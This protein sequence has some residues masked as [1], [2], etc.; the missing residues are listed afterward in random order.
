MPF[1][2]YDSIQVKTGGYSAKFG[3]STGG[4]MNATS[5]SGTNEFK[6]GSNFYFDKEIET[7]PN[8]Y[9][10][11]N[12]KDAFEETNAD[13]YASGPI[14]KDRLFFYALY[15][16]NSEDEEY[17]GML[18]GRGYKATRDTDFWGVKLDGYISE[19][20]RV[21]L[22]AF[23][24]ERETIEGAYEYDSATENVGNYLGDTIYERGGMNWI[25]TYTGNL[26][27]TMT[28]SMS[29]GENEANRTTAPATA[30][31]PVVY[32]YDGGFIA[33]GDWTNF[34]VE[35]GEDKREM[36][37]VD[38]AWDLNDHFIEVGVDQESNTS[39]SATINSGG[40]YWL[41]DPNNTYNECTAAECPSGA[42]VRLRT[43]NVGGEFDVESTAFYIQDTWQATDQL[44]IQAGLRNESF[45]NNNGAGD[46][47]IEIDNQWAPRLSAV[48]DPTG[49][50]NQKV[51]ANWGMYYLPIA[52]NT[53]IRMAGNETYIQDYFDWDGSCLNADFTPCNVGGQFDQDLF[54]N[55]TVPD[56]RSL[57]DTN[58]EPMYQSEFILGYEYIT[59]QGMELGVK[60]IY[61][62]LETSIE[63]V[64]IDAAVI[65]YYNTNGGWT[66]G[67]TVEET[68]TGFHQYVLTNPG[69]DMEI[70]IP[71]TDE[72]VSLD[73]GALGYPEAERQYGALEFTFRRPFDGK[74]MVDASYTW[75]HSWGNNEGY[76]RSDNGQD[77]AGLTT[78]FD[79]PGLLD[80][81][82][83]NLPNDRRHTV[84]AFGTYQFDMGLRM[85][86]NFMWQSGR[87]QNCFGVHPTDGF[88]AAYGAES[89]YCQG[90]LASRG[91]FGRT[92]NRWNL[93]L[94]A[95]YPVEFANNQ[96][97]MVSL[98]VF[99]LLNNDAVTEVVETGDTDG[100]AVNPFFNEPVQYQSPRAVRLGVRY[101]FN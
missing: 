68:F 100:G 32:E 92:D 37:R 89:F 49:A 43:Y 19:N 31:I 7:S 58:I 85:G 62:N 55:G 84:K 83:G 78:N 66:A 34:T 36:M 75:G 40:A 12:D 70:Y 28:L 21:E 97:V 25:A 94:N 24:D 29:Y 73:A 1:E 56:T 64:A 98:D 18:S 4:V 39:V 26:T 10:A 46:P 72:F 93:D 63:D 45:K 47:F 101:E 30:D 27:D 22:T 60:G 82:K 67:G 76:V 6:F 53:N 81:G 17:Y 44:S 88:A 71:E 38:F 91:S 74:W 33:R 15:S 99:N 35:T 48:F 51:F 80:G 50:G 20:H 14:I 11:D 16:N 79:Q 2:F 5:K 90:E 23:S 87:P 65:D 8:T 59:E 57:V 52:S 3:R 42:N 95:Q 61:R 41:L 86:A 54:G 77:D 9:V 69:N 13:I 96:K